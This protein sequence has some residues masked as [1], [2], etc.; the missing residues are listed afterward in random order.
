M[1]RFLEAVQP[2]TQELII[3]FFPS[4]KLKIKFINVFIFIT[5]NIATLKRVLRNLMQNAEAIIRAGPNINLRTV[6]IIAIFVPHAMILLCDAMK[7]P[8]S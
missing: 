4:N 8:V 6:V 1:A 2:E 3:D 5:C 7:R